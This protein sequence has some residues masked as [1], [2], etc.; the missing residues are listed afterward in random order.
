M[1]W[2]RRT[3]NGFPEK[4]KIVLNGRKREL[5]KLSEV[6]DWYEGYVPSTG[7]RRAASES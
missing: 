1:W 6:L 7:G 3:R 4:H 5:L 2:V